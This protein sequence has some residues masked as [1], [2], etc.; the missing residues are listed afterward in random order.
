MQQGIVLHFENVVVALAFFVVAAIA[1]FAVFNPDFDDSLIQRIALSAAC[2]AALGSGWA[3]L[4]EDMPSGVDLAA[5]AAAAYAVECLR[6]HWLRR[7]KRDRRAED[8]RC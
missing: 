6:L 2:I 5:V 4:R 3:S 8:R 1:L 7:H